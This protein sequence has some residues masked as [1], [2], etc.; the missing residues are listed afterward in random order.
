MIYLAMFSVHGVA[1]RLVNNELEDL[2]GS[3]HHLIEIFS[4]HFPEETEISMKIAVS[5]PRLE[6]STSG[7]KCTQSSNKQY[8]GVVRRSKRKYIRTH[9]HYCRPHVPRDATPFTDKLIWTNFLRQQ[10]REIRE[11]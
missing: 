7:K 2:E 4:Q 11:Q 10:G 8:W 5:R 9:Q 6:A 3:G 1:G